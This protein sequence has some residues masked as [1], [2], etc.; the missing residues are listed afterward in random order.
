VANC[1]QSPGTPDGALLAPAAARMQPMP[2]TNSSFAIRFRSWRNRLIASEAFRNWMMRVPGLRA[3][4]NRKANALFR[5]TAGFVFTQVLNMCVRLR[6]FEA[7]RDRQKTTE[8]LADVAKLPADRMQLLL[9]QAERLD[10][11]LQVAPRCWMLDDAGAVVA[12]DPGIAAMI[13]HHDMFYADL[14]ATEELLRRP[15]ADTRLKRFWAY[16]HGDNPADI[17]PETAHAYSALMHDSQSMFSDCVLAAHDFGRYRALLD[18]GGGDG[19][20]LSACAKAHPDLKLHL[21]DVPAVAALAEQQFRNKGLAERSSA[22]GGDFV[23]DP[24]PDAADCVCLVRILCDHDDARV[25][26]I[27]AN[28]HRSLKPGTQV[29]IAEAMAGPAEGAQLAAVYFSLYFLAMGSGRCRSD[30]EIKAMLS[31]AGFRSARTVKTTNPLLAT[32]VLSER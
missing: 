2:P 30:Q 23:R 3:L 13:R 16:A 31:E 1:D 25:K 20:F 28:L 6:V 18:V 12:S 24:L 7:L 17:D 5:I 21:F 26:A 4:A 10:L 29:V 15:G 14:A 8:E 32:I 22:H 19:S 11:V 27:L 9:E